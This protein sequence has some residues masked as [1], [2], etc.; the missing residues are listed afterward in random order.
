MVA[1]EAAPWTAGSPAGEAVS[2]L[3]AALDELGHHVTLVLPARGAS[4]PDADRVLPLKVELGASIYDV[5][6]HARTLSRGRQ[7]VVV[8]CPSSSLDGE[9]SEWLRSGLVARAALEFAEREAP[10]R[11]VHVVHA[12]EWQ[13]ALVLV[14]LRTDG[15]CWPRLAQAAR[16]LTL[17]QLAT[18][19]VFPRDAVPSLGLPWEAFSIE[20]GEFWGRFNALKAGAND[21]HFVTTVS[22]TYADETRRTHG[23]GLEGVLAGLGSRYVGILDGLDGIRWNPAADRYLPAAFDAERP[24]GK[25]SCKRA[26]LE[27]LGLPFGDDALARP[28]IGMIGPF[29]DANGFDLVATSRETL[30]TLDASW[31]FVGT[32]EPA[33][34]SLLADLARRYP[35]RVGFGAG[36]AEP[37]THLAIAGADMLLVPARE[38]PSGFPALRALR[39]GAV[40]VVRATGGLADAVQPYTARAKRANG[41]V[42]REASSDAL[43][44][45]V[46][47]AIRLFEDR[48]AWRGLVARGLAENHDWRLGAREYVK[49]YRQARHEA[50][51][52]IAR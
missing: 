43:V 6:C 14:L 1:P 19:G 42:L 47:Q 45:L 38:E 48:A 11:P 32:G 31:A 33:Y 49:V 51:A 4:A 17:H 30:P 39:Y 2:A 24:D 5:A 36:D 26:L 23:H 9:A 21:S 7:L 44:R 34:E 20:R 35:S 10:D 25:R 41:L 52:R 29:T 28:L 8:Q 16:V 3:A 46:R 40:P 22:P 37:A 12:H 15:A 13:G 27:R 50:A 18:Q